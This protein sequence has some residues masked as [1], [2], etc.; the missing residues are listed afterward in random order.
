[1]VFCAIIYTTLYILKIF[2]VK[3]IPQNYVFLFNYAVLQILLFHIYR[4]QI[5]T[6]KG[7]T[8]VTIT[9]GKT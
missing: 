1:M 9:V 2:I 8:L 3:M 7:R 5:I 4:L 6:K